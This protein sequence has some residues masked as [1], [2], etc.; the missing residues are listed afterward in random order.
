MITQK[1]SQSQSQ[2]M[3]F[4]KPRGSYLGFTLTLEGI[5]PGCNKLQAIGDAKPPTTI[6]MVRS[7]VGLSNFFRMHIKDFAVI[8]VLLFKVVRKD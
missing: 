6:K 5:K 8:A 7:F 4:W 3:C 2:E 1:S